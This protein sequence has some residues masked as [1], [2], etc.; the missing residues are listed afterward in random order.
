MESREGKMEEGRKKERKG[1]KEIKESEQQSHVQF[2]LRTA[3]KW[4]LI[5]IHLNT[6]Q[7]NEIQ[8][9]EL[10]QLQ[11]CIKWGADTAADKS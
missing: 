11:G 6:N 9:D 2:L 7:Y 10:H 3:Q 1:K 5:Y 8:Q 4:C